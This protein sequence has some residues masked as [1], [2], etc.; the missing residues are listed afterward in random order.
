MRLQTTPNT[1][2][3]TTRTEAVRWP[4]AVAYREAI[5][6]PS[7][8]LTDPLLSGAEVVTDRRGLPVAYA[9]RFA[10]VF[11]MKT[12]NGEQWALRCF[13]S[14][15]D[16]GGAARAF[17]YRLVQKYVD[18]DR[19]TFVPFRYVESGMRVNGA[20]YPVLSMRWATG[21]PLGRWV[22]ENLHNSGALR[23][24][25][26]TLT[27]LLA[28]LEAK[29]ISHG[30]WQHDNLLV[31]EEGWHATL[32]D[33]DGMYVPELAGRPAPELGHA[34][35]QHP[36][37]TLEH[38]GPGLDRFACLSIQTSLLALAHDPGLW[39]RFSDGESLLFKKTDYVDPAN[40]PAF[41]AVK[42]L[43]VLYQDETLADAVVRLE[44]ACRAGALSTLLP[45][46]LQEA[47]VPESEKRVTPVYEPIKA[48]P[49]PPPG[50]RPAPG[51]LPIQ[52]WWMTPEIVTPPPVHL[53]SAGTS[54][55]SPVSAVNTVTAQTGVNLR[56][57]VLAAAAA[58]TG[59]SLASL[60]ASQAN[61]PR[62]HS[63]SAPQARP[64]VFLQRL[65]TPE[66]LRLE[67]NHLWKWRA[68]GVAMLAFVLM[69]I[70]FAVITRNPALPVYFAWLL[71]YAGLGYAK[72]PR[73]AAYEELIAEI[74]KMENLIADRNRRIEELGGGNPPPGSQAAATL[75]EFVENQLTQVSINK[76]LT[77]SG[78]QVSTLR[79]LRSEGINNAADLQKRALAPANIPALP[80]HQLTA[81]QNWVRELEMQAAG[82]W[83]KSLG[84]HRTTPTD[85]SRLQNEVAEFERHV[86]HLKRER[87]QFPDASFQNYLALLLGTASKTNPPAPTS[88]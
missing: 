1:G 16:E 67:Q 3:Q 66:T 7:A 50:S 72:W 10:V 64:F 47:E 51:T 26:A 30:D 46:H 56:S 38:F 86:A 9:G 29:N 58:S 13:T 22:E 31:S 4:D 59:T 48:P 69:L 17:R 19:T 68:G 27:A 14:P 49:P 18:A 73:K 74:S 63:V 76:V 53:S 28:R 15:G 55:A 54:S 65:Q 24:L 70:Y 82:D 71:N 84:L 77:V 42:Q 45:L 75:H 39:A 78:I 34:N 87:D 35:Y 81:L 11:K 36:A 8:V 23:T 33:Y 43:A 20:M 88:P 12:A 6:T 61:R 40:S 32:V 25:C 52:N 21:Q 44:D 79:Q 62:T 37:R 85:V 57:E 41:D 83:R 60:T 5:Q 80:P 2:T